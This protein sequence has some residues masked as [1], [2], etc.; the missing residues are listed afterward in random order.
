MEINEISGKDFSMEDF[1]TSLFKKMHDVETC[2]ELLE[3]HISEVKS[4]P[5][6]FLFLDP[7]IFRTDLGCP[8]FM[9]QTSVTVLNRLCMTLLLRDE[10][11]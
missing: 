5:R 2:R 9:K 1:S 7:P 3:E 6:C 11:L 8:Y 10:D 4:S